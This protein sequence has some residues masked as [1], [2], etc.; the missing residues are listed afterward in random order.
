MPDPPRPVRISFL[1][2]SFIFVVPT[3]TAKMSATSYTY[4]LTPLAYALP[5]LHA[6]RHT[7]S[8][9][10]GLLL[11]SVAANEVVIDDAIPLLHN[12]TFLSPMAEVGLSLAQEEAKRQGSKVVGVY[13]VHEMEVSGLGRAG[14][15]ILDGLKKGFEGAIGLMVRH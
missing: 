11:G 6:A 13:V 5:L 9:V 1:Q 2:S 10:L 12:Y 4:T 8:T 7:S 15:R 14:E 3:N